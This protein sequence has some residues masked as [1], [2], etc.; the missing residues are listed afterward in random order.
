[1]S[2][3]RDGPTAN[4]IPSRPVANSNAESKPS[5]KSSNPGGDKR[6]PPTPKL[7]EDEERAI[8]KRRNIEQLAKAR[9]AKREKNQRKLKQRHEHVDATNPTPEPNRDNDDDND[10]PT[11]DDHEHDSVQ[12][13]YDSDVDSVGS[14]HSD[15]S[16][17]RRDSSRKRRREEEDHIH[18]AKHHP[19]KRSRKQNPK[20]DSERDSEEDNPRTITDH[21]RST[22]GDIF[23]MFLVSGLASIVFVAFTAAKQ[24]ILG[25]KET[26][27]EQLLKE[28]TKQPK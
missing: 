3:E 11:S 27:E 8:Q 24:S 16:A 1:M 15:N 13:N 19:S 5:S 12:H 6:V 26:R 17:T 9:D 21:L 23:N 14:N 2:T 7:S 10:V 20:R 4:A 22:M 25:N 18:H 28:W